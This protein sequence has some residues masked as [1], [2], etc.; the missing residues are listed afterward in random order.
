MI[1]SWCLAGVTV[2]AF[3]GW[4]A[5]QTVDRLRPG[6]SQRIVMLVLGGA[7]LRWALAAGLLAAALQHGVTSGLLA[8]SGLWLARWGTVGWASVCARESGSTIT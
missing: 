6:T 2:G 4:T 7:S 1:L 3:N 8:F 5:W